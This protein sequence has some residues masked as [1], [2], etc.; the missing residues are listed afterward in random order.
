[1]S[2]EQ[3]ATE[4]KPAKA[5]ATKKPKKITLEDLE[6]VSGGTEKQD[7]CTFAQLHSGRCKL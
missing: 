2:K 5:P 6:D 3:K 7:T 4:K 1:M